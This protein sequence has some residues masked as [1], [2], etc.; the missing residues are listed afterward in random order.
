MLLLALELYKKWS[1]RLQQRRYIAILNETGD[2]GA[3]GTSTVLSEPSVLDVD[4]Q[5]PEVGLSLDRAREKQAREQ[6]V[7]AARTSKV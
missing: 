7:E 1:Q 6:E 4:W 3:D 5:E 2:I